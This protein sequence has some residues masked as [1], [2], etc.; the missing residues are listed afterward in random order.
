MERMEF[1]T[2]FWKDFSL[3]F[4]ADA[5]WCAGH[6]DTTRLWFQEVFSGL[7]LADCMEVSKAI[8]AGHLD[9]WAPRG[10]EKVYDRQQIPAVYQRHVGAMRYKRRMEAEK[11]ETLRREQ[12]RKAQTS[13]VIA[14]DKSM[15]AAYRECRRI[16]AGGGTDE[17]VAR[18]LDEIYPE[19]V[20]KFHPLPEQRQQLLSM[21]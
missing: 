7:G 3:R 2:V 8:M 1:N 18:Y 9:G 16:K 21:P 12:M 20:S 17:E 19:T 15:S 5:Q 13:G 4:P 6:P 10:N 14:G 11:A